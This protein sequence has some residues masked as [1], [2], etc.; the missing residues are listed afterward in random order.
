MAPMEIV[1]A[2]LVYVEV[3][4]K[5]QKQCVCFWVLYKENIIPLWKWIPSDSSQLISRFFVFAQ[6]QVFMF[7]FLP[8]SP[9]AHTLSGR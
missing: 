4:K 5:I 6:L 1:G 7:F 2:M 8:I 9:T 3:L